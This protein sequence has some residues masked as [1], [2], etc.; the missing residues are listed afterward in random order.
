MPLTP[1]E[2][3]ILKLCGKGYS[4]AEAGPRLG[5]S[6]HTVDWHTRKI[7]R[8]LRAINMTHGVYKGCQSGLI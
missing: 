4:K 6:M 1:T 7:T 3:K 5:M 2:I 8:K